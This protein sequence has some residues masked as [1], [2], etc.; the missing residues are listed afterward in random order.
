MACQAG[1]WSCEARR[2]SD[3]FLALAV[4]VVATVTVLTTD[5]D[6]NVA[7]V[8]IVADV[9]LVWLV[10][11]CILARRWSTAHGFATTT[12]AT[13]SC[14]WSCRV[15]LLLLLLLWMQL[16]EQSAAAAAGATRAAAA[17]VVSTAA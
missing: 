5:D 7:V 9:A 13:G 2:C 16:E 10:Q 14:R 11:L 1:S 8:V 6:D 3:S 17:V 4:V 12:T 15:P